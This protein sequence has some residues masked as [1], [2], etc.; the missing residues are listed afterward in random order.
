MHGK[1]VLFYL[2]DGCTEMNNVGLPKN[3]AP[4]KH[5]TAAMLHLPSL[6]LK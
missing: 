6:M 2:L 1:T 5:L 4:Y 3:A